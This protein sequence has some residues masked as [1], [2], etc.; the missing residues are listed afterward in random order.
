MF[1]DDIPGAKPVNLSI[2]FGHK[3]RTM[4]GTKYQSQSNVDL[5]KS[6]DVQTRTQPLHPVP[7]SNITINRRGVRPIQSVFRGMHHPAGK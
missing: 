4:K 3:D 7:N 2:K 1:I 5:N 6:V